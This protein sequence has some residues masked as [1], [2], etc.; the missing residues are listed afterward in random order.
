[1][2][3]ATGLSDC[4]LESKSRNDS[5]NILDLDSRGK[6][7]ISPLRILLYGGAVISSE[8]IR[9]V[10]C[11]GFVCF[12]TVAEHRQRS[13][14]KAASYLTIRIPKRITQS[15]IQSIT[16]IGFISDSQKVVLRQH[17]SNTTLIPSMIY[18][19]GHQS[20]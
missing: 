10:F 5:G 9:V 14:A 2:T 12:P 16:G 6:S 18:H 11:R 4:P 8:D 1:M 7:K 20:L 19:C 15:K 13:H 17:P 3:E